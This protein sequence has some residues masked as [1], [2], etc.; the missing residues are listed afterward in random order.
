MRFEDFRKVR[1][2]R[3]AGRTRNFSPLILQ[4]KSAI[5]SRFEHVHWAHRSTASGSIGAP[6][7]GSGVFL[8]PSCGVGK[9]SS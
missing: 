7:D 2:R 9:T 3:S 5:G 4:R 8:S 6:A 1:E